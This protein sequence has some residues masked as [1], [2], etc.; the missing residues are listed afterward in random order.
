MSVAGSSQFRRRTSVDK[1]PQSTNEFSGIELQHCDRS[2]TATPAQTRSGS[3]MR[4]TLMP[5]TATETL[6]FM[7]DLHAVAGKNAPKKLFTVTLG[8]AMASVGQLDGSE[9]VSTATKMKF[10]AIYFFF[11]LGLT[12]YNKAVMIQVGLPFIRSSFLRLPSL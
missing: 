8:K 4:R 10:L 6:R 5:H 2:P 11:N 1:M 3:P 12:L 7:S 9:G